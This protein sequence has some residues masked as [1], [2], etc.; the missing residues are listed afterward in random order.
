M[1]NK[2]Q[3]ISSKTLNQNLKSNKTRYF[4]D[5]LGSD[6]ED[7]YYI[8]KYNG[9]EYTSIN[10]FKDDFVNKEINIDTIKIACSKVEK[11][12][13]IDKKIYDGLYDVINSKMFNV[14][15]KSY[16]NERKN[17]DILKIIKEWK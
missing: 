15:C 7:D 6:I 5:F 17:V 8:T 16:I 9:I 4:I 14:L 12:V 2:T 3:K 1:E 10:Y 11:A 13:E